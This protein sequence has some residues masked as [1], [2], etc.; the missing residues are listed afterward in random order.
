MRNKED[1]E[2]FY[3]VI[4]DLG[5]QSWKLVW[6]KDSSVE[7]YCW[8][9]IKKIN[10]GP[11]SENVK[12]L[13]LHEIAHI[14]TCLGYGNKHKKEFWQKYDMLLKKYL[15]GTELSESEKY[16]KKLNEE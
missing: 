10:I 13:M 11:A 4:K 9:N 2:F 15:P 14:D 3:N 6:Y 16:L 12:R 8:R 5:H 7:G 1:E